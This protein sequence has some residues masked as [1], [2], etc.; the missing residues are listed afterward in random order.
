MSS[1]DPID[2]PTFSTKRYKKG[3]WAEPFSDWHRE[4]LHSCFKFLDVDYLGFVADYSRRIVAPY[5]LIERIRVPE[6]AIEDAPA[7]YPLKDHKEMVYSA[8]SE[9]LDVPAFT[10]WHT[11]ACDVFWFEDLDTGERTRVEGHHEF[12]DVL[13]TYRLAKKEEVGIR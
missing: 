2:G 13:D 7:R 6:D 3:D 4:N 11:D 12:C 1:E 8:L 9:G 5:I 10:L